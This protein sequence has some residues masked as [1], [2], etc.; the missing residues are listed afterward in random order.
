MNQIK[1]AKTEL[2]NSN[3]IE[4]ISGNRMT[5]K[6][7]IQKMYS[8][9][10]KFGFADT[11]KVV[12]HKKKYYVLEGQ[13]RLEALKQHKIDTVP[14]SVIDWID[15]TFVDLQKFIISLNAHNRKWDLA[16]YIH[17]YSS[18]KI[19]EYLWLKKQIAT[20]G[21]E[22]STGVIVTCYNGVMRSQNALKEGKLSFIDE[23]FSDNLVYQFSIL[24]KRFSKKQLPAQVLRQAAYLILKKDDLYGYLKTFRLA[25]MNHLTVS[26]EPLPDGDEAFK[27][28]FDNVVEELYT[29]RNDNN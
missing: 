18:N 8:L 27:Y 12:K 2:L 17:S 15:G 13:N 28:W 21:K 10:G 6:P 20:Y 24:V 11:I 22:L 19:R 16:D 4:T 14:C 5:N 25:V 29:M 26:K 23:T 3:I 7:H 9:I 1:I